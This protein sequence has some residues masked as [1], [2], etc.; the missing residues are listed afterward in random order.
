[1]DICL[2]AKTS[3]PVTGGLGRHVF[4]LGN[5]LEEKGHN[6]TLITADK[7]KKG[8]ELKPELVE[9][10]KFTNHLF[11]N[12]YFA[13]PIMYKEI[14]VR[15]EFDVIHCHEM[16]F[17]SGIF[18]KL[19]GKDAEFVYTVH[20][21][22]EK[23]ASR[24]LPWIIRKYLNLE[25]L[26][27]TKIADKI[28]S[29][30]KHTLKDIKK[31]YRPR[32]SKLVQIYNGVDT[33]RFKP[34]ETFNNQILFVGR[35]IEIKGPHLVLEAFSSIASEFPDCKLIIV[36]Q[37]KMGEYL[38]DKAEYENLS[39]RIEFKQ[40]VSDEQLAKLY[41]QSIF[42]MPS[43]YEGQG[44]VYL[45]AM[46]SGAPV[47]ACE[48]SAIPEMIIN[49]QNGFLSPRN[50]KELAK[51]LKKLLTEEELR[52]DFGR[53]ARKSMERFDWDNIIEETEVEY[54]KLVEK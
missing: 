20:G 54:E 14:M 11:F 31:L 39:D 5:R 37:G 2:V 4:E 47:I 49:G 32:D 40:D 42:I 29:V 28:I 50:A 19:S 30:S 41:A 46:S 15:G 16:V 18:A 38:K 45:E 22:P 43:S 6:V 7:P 33:S 23:L 21:I 53:N 8:M 10:R 3:D 36:G 17:W 52:E 35:L 27:F 26:L 9:V 12:Q 25:Q 24:K 13:A 51:Y 44:I 1:M 48:N 34:C